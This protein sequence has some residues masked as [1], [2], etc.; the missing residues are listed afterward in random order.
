LSNGSRLVVDASEHTVEAGLTCPKELLKLQKR[1]VNIYSVPNLHAKVFVLGSAA[2]IGSTNVSDSSACRLLEALLMTTEKSAVD[3][4]RQFVRDLCLYELTPRV[5]QRLAKKWR[6]PKTGK[7]STGP[8]DDD[9]TGPIHPVLPRVVIAQ[10]SRDQFTESEEEEHSAGMKIAGRLK[11]PS[12]EYIVDSFQSVVGP[13][14]RPCDIV[15]VVW[16]VDK[17]PV[18]VRPPANVLHVKHVRCDGKRST[19]VY[20]ERDS[21]RTDIPRRV[22]DSQ[23][24]RNNMEILRGQSVVRNQLVVRRLLAAWK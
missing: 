2:F 21:R 17:K 11:K 22:L 14:Y 19:F 23:L 12:K 20:M 4:A 5:L 3:G 10:L 1:G 18:V 16:S 15:V 8:E 6:P 7:P 24:G 9:G 13:S